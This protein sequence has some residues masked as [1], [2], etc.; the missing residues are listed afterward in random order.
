M[1]KLLLFLLPLLIL[2]IGIK[3]FRYLMAT[4][5]KREPIKIEEQTWMVTA[6]PVI[7][8]SL[9]PTVTL[10]GRVESPRAT[11]LRAP[12]LSLVANAE[13]VEVAVLEG[14]KVSKEQVVI[15][16]ENQESQ[17]NLKQRDAELADI[18]SQIELENLRQTNNLAVIAHEEAL[19]KLAQKSFQRIQK[20]KQQQVSSEAAID[21]AQQA[22]ERQMLTVINRRAEIKNHQTYLAQL[23]AKQARA[24][25]QR[26]LARLELA[27]TQIQTPFAG[28]IAK[29][30]VAVGDRVRSG[31]ALLSMYDHTDLEIRAQIPNRYQGIIFDA[32]ADNYPLLAH[33]RI[34]EHPLLFQL[35]RLAGQIGQNSGGIDGL[36]R[37]KQGTDW[38]R[39][40][41]FFTL[42]L[43]LPE[44]HRVVAL[45]FEAVYG[46]NRIYKLVDGRM[47]GLAVER[48]GEQ[49]MSS[50]EST[51]LVRSAEL[52]AGDQVIVTQL[53]NAMDGLKVK[54][55][56]R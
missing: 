33:A 40:G 11:T 55:D 50:G 43:A 32:M 8:T 6:T 35:D 25:A 31:D 2:A 48:V 29:V 13:V 28:I 9:A 22:I 37:V 24:I 7:P 41:Q 54:L 23:N 34:N 18:Q 36:F 44:Q 17:L 20:L 39:L 1:K 16:L 12:T 30:L 21:E 51:I 19:L 53:P 4:K 3:G 46:T 15:R 27:R 49:V 47:Q 26:D 5:P 42:A 10:Y 52:I 38:L 56:S 45:P 14:E